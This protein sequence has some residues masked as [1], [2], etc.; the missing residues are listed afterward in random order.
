MKKLLI[1]LMTT[2][3]AMS[4]AASAQA[5]DKLKACW[6]Y[7]G[8]IGDFGYSYQHDQGRLE[9]EKALGDKVETAY[10]E[11][12]SEGPDADRAFERLAREGCKIIFG[13]SFG[14]M[15]AEVKVAKKFP[16][17]MFEHA[18]GYKTGDNLGIYN[19]RF[20]EGRY[21]LGQIAAKESKSGVA[22]YI[23]SFPIPEVVMGINS[24]MLGAQSINPNFKAKIVWVNSWFDPGKE[25]DAAKALFDQGADIIV[26]HTD[27]TAA[28]QVA[29]ERKLHGFGQ[30]S[31][32]IKFAPNA[33]LTSLTD[34][35]GPYYISRVQAAIDGSWKPDNVW[36]GIKDG[37]VKL[38]PYTNMPDD[39]KAMAE[40]TE[41][42]IAG[43]WNP[44]TGP[45][46]KQDGSAW[47]KDGEVADDGTLLGMNFYVKGVDD[48]LPQ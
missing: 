16:K 17:V 10:L 41:K 20:Y 35:W 2:T 21:V 4:L 39:V 15:D 30:S 34:E 13:T 42:K 14:F 9:V 12:V 31:D 8:P 43:G 36:L 26:Q 27:S 29:E 23:V 24:F 11:N 46:A 19:A 32:M 18:T 6:V 5:A 37:A 33:Q 47:L 22:G 28:L 48:K 3:A 1:A 38:A 40:A 44:F 7:T 25:A 45:I